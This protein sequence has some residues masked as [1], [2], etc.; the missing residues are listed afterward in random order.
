MG[1]F[2]SYLLQVSLVMALLFLSYKVL[3]SSA[4]FH[5]FKRFTLLG[6]LLAAW[7]LPLAM[8]KTELPLSHQ[9]SGGV[10]VERAIEAG[11]GKGSV[12]IGVP[13]L[14]EVV[15]S[16]GEAVP[17]GTW[18]RW[19]VPVYVTGLLCVFLLTL[20]SV[21][22]LVRII[23][24]GDRRHRRGFSIV[25]ND[26]VPGPFSWGRYVVLRRQDCDSDLSLVMKH[27]LSHIRRR[28]WIDNMFAQMN[29]MLLWFNPVSY[30]IMRELKRI[31]EFEADQAVSSGQARRYQ[32]MLIKKAVGS[33]FPTF[34]DSLNHSQ[35]KIRITMMMKRKSS[36]ARRLTALALPGA[37]LVAISI[38][39]QPS[40]A[41]ILADVSASFA[42]AVPDRKVSQNA[43]DEQIIAVVEALGGVEEG[44]S[45]QQADV[46]EES[47]PAPEETVVE[48]SP[49]ETA[50]VA[51]ESVTEEKAQGDV[52]VYFVDGKQ[53]DG[54][55]R[56][57][58]P[59][60]I[61]SMT[62]V[63]NDP[64]YPQGKIMIELGKGGEEVTLAAEHAAEFKG[65][66]KALYELI[67]EN[68]QYPKGISGHVRA[69]I[70]F[71]VGV[72]GDV[73]DFKVLR[74]AGEAADAEA[75][76]VLSLTDKMWN[77]ATTDGKPVTTK[78]VLPVV[79]KAK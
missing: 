19:I 61:K 39:S 69:V 68:M 79:F 2:I 25:L 49:A 71:T 46:T 16:S 51:D 21:L 27:E 47:V 59:A 11:T 34:A 57:L 6:V 65:G 29:M 77:P 28:H 52:P 15:D 41:Q 33:S 5:A 18:F 9:D 24:M 55:L 50:A 58:K 73:S 36:S 35:L 45:R 64:R 26:G 56:D 10:P 75:I 72:N 3:L 4:T 23:R 22:R 12:E 74:S 31:H 20:V 43:A 14:V 8:P 38:L 40:V 48:E 67:A 1:A 13:V 70:Q 30:M 63:K 17:H 62:V 7:I 53:F 44:S 66:Y 42:A 37:A 76:R 54:D 60:D 32:L 78:Y